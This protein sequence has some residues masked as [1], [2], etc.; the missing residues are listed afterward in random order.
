MDDDGGTDRDHLAVEELL[1]GG[2]V[3]EVGER[4]EGQADVQLALIA[5]SEA[6]QGATHTFGAGVPIAEGPIDESRR[7]G[8]HVSTV[9]NTMQNK[10]LTKVV[11]WVVVIGMVLSMGLATIAILT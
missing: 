2:G 6:P 8:R 9:S 4:P 5:L 10:Q 3:A 1:F 7:H 11:I